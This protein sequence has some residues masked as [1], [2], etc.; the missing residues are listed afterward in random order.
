MQSRIILVC[1]NINGMLSPATASD[2]PPLPPPPGRGSDLR[3]AERHLLV[4]GVGLAH[5]AALWGLLQ[6]SA[7]QDAVRQVAPL[8]VDFIT[9]EQPKPEAP[10]PQPPPPPKPRPQPVP[11]PAA[12]PVLAAPP[13]PAAEL[14]APFVVPPPPPEP[15]PVVTAPLAPPA[16]PKPPAPLAPPAPPAPPPPA[17]PAPRVIPA[18]N[19]AYTTP[20]PIEVPLASRRMGEQGTVQLRV[21]VGIDGLPKTVT[22]QRSSGHV[23]LDEQAVWAM[24]RARFKP[25]TDDGVPIEWIVIAPLQYEIE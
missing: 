19:V 14:P 21:L 4:A 15:V 2:S 20:P 8:L 24:Q 9:I 17:P 12:P 23:R 3:P 5:L 25:Q 16:P 18:S 1:A 13:A 22:V 11:R 10:P 7:V 6:V